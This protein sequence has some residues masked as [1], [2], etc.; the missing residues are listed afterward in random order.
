MIEWDDDTHGP[1]IQAKSCALCPGVLDENGIEK[2]RPARCYVDDALLAAIGRMRM[3]KLLAA[4]IEAI[5]FV[6]GYPDISRRRCAFSLEKLEK[7]KVGPHQVLLGLFYDTIKFTK[8]TTLD[9]RLD[10]LAYI[11][12]EW[13]STRDSITAHDMQVLVG[14]LA[15]LAKGAR[16]VY[17]I[18]S[19]FYDQIAI[20][21]A[22]N[23][24]LLHY[25][26]PRFKGLISC[27]KKGQMG[28]S[29][30]SQDSG[31]IVAF[32]LKQASQL[33]HRSK[34]KHNISALLRADIEFFRWALLPDSGIPWS[35]PLA[36]V[37]PRT[38]IGI[39]FGDACLTGCG[40]YCVELIQILVASL[41][42]RRDYPANAYLSR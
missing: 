9:Y 22:S 30:L 4:T 5:F 25:H 35:S 36:H 12:K 40:G 29:K 13:P 16:W 31:R 23:H 14:K 28:T 32:A 15:R 3:L 34:S 6:M 17:H 10:L 7:L 1:F 39:P 19:H 41:S 26:S 27:I 21:L 38:P 2:K 11:D 20:A 8:G 37:V 33:V 24:R 18:L 42:T